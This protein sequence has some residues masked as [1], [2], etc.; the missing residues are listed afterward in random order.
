[1]GQSNAQRISLN[2]DAINVLLQYFS[3]VQFY[4]FGGSALLKDNV[5]SSTP[6]NYWLGQTSTGALY[7]SQLM[8]DGI[9]FL[10]TYNPDVILWIQGEQDGTRITSSNSAL[11][12]KA[13]LKYLFDQFLGFTDLV[14]TVTIGRRLSDKDAGFHLVRTMTQQVVNEMRNVEIVR[15]NYSLELEDVVHYSHDSQVELCTDLIANIGSYFNGTS[16]EIGSKVIEA[17]GY[18]RAVDVT[19]NNPIDLIGSYAHRLFSIRDLNGNLTQSP[20][21]LEQLSAIKVRLHF[22][23]L[24]IKQYLC[25]AVGQ[26]TGIHSN[27]TINIKSNG[28][29]IQPSMLRIK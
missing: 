21:D 13:G 6:S 28:V 12:Y 14:A 16:I 27:S 23:D 29:D 26:L 24:P 9:E 19:F 15:D 1:M 10:S 18:S 5:S 3:D 22:S 8:Q 20:F 7:N 25:V 2:Q 4:A 11:E 17:K